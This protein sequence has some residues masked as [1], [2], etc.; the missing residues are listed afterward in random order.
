MSAVPFSATLEARRAQTFPVLTPEEIAR[1]H[2]FGRRRRFADGEH[3][4]ASGSVSPASMS[5]SPARS[6]SP[7]AMH[8]DTTLR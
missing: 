6:A 3:V 4:L 7:V 1:L 8:T 2:R 5:C